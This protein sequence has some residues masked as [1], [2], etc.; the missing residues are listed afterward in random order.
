MLPLAY[1]QIEI[2]QTA[3]DTLVLNY[4]FSYSAILHV[5][6]HNSYDLNLIAFLN[7]YNAVVLPLSSLRIWWSNGNAID[8]VERLFD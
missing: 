2:R 7:D 6:S 4:M 5:I 8:V 1:K 3:I